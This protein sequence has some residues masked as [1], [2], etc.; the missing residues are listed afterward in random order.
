MTLIFFV[1][2]ILCAYKWITTRFVLNIFIHYLKKKDFPAPSDAELKECTEA[3]YDSMLKKL[4][5]K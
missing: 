5:K 2:T 1:T 4:F 3:V